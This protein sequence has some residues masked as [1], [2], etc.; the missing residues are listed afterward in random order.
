MKDIHARVPINRIAARAISAGV[1]YKPQKTIRNLDTDLPI[2][3]R[4]P[5]QTERRSNGFVDLSG[6]RVGRF[7]VIGMASQINAMWVVR[8]DCGRYTTRTAKAIKNP[9]NTNDRCEH[10]RHLAFLKCEEHWRRTGRHLN[11]SEV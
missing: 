5:T 3:T 6:Q 1:A 7:T 10:C 4:E 11:W 9:Q 2:K 8:C